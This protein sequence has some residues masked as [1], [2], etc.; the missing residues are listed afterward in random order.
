MPWVIDRLTSAEAAAV[1]ADDA[2]APFTHFALLATPLKQ[3]F[4]PTLFALKGKQPIAVR[5]RWTACSAPD[6]GRLASVNGLARRPGPRDPAYLERWRS[7]FDFILVLNA[8]A[9]WISKYGGIVVGIAAIAW[10]VCALTFGSR[11]RSR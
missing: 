7:C 6:G 5:P 9:D 11:R 8:D 1:F 4:V 3:A 2:I 10:A